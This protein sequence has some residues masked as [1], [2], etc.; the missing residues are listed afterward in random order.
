MKLKIV[1]EG[2]GDTTKVV[3]V[4]TGEEVENVISLDFS[5]DAF[6]SDAAIVIRD[7]HLSID[8]LNVQEIRQGDSGAH[9]G[10]AGDPDNQQHSEPTSFQV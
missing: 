9:D 10:T 3:N 4:A 1:S 7:P 5:M 8:N 2:T 6:H